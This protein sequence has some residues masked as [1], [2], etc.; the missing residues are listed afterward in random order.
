MNLSFQSIDT[1]CAGID[2]AQDRPV[3]D[4]SLLE[5]V[6]LFA[7]IYLGQFIRYHNRRGKL[8]QVKMPPEDSRVRKYLA[9]IRFW[10]RFNFS[11]EMVKREGM[12]RF[13]SPTSLND[14][15]DLLPHPYV[16]EETSELVREV[17]AR[18]S[19]RVDTDAVLEVAAELC[20]NFAQ[21]ARTDLATL[22][23][24]YYPKIRQF[25]VAVGDCG[26][27]IRQT[28]CENPEYAYLGARTH[29]E[30]IVKAFEPMVSRRKEGGTGLTILRD[31]A[32][33]LGGSLRL[34]SNDGFYYIGEGRELMGKQACELPG[35][36]VEMLFPEE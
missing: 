9:R 20:D 3:V 28:L 16:G 21:H 18:S 11:A 12:L 10:E 32:L 29:A 30:A 4:L 26:L 36:Q 2:L 7:V 15:V 17:L 33:R 6:E 8:F 19:V 13:T 27:G 25:A 34:A 24:Q 1:F 14:I 23:V 5:F 31:C 35:V 22:A